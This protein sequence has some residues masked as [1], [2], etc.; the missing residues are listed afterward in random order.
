MN[1]NQQRPVSKI[2]VRSKISS[3]LGFLAAGLLSTFSKPP[4]KVS[5]EDLK[6]ADFRTSAQR[7]GVRLTEKIRNV[8]RFRWLK[9]H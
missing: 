5:P 4:A 3:F 6:R 9:K 2:A 7:M 1:L 8:F